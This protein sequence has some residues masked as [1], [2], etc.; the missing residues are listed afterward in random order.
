MKFVFSNSGEKIK[1]KMIS[2]IF[3]NFNINF[4]KFL[5]KLLVKK[6]FKYI[7]SKKLKLNK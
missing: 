4:N 2:K 7:E 6:I 3:T 1:L 5:Y